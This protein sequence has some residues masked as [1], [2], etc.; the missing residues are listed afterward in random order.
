MQIFVLTYCVPSLP[1]PSTSISRRTNV[2]S[3]LSVIR[4]KKRYGIHYTDSRNM[5]PFRCMF[6]EIFVL[7]LPHLSSPHPLISMLQRIFSVT[8]FNLQQNKDTLKAKLKHLYCIIH[9]LVLLTCILSL[10]ALLSHCID[11]AT[12]KS[13]LYPFLAQRTTQQQVFC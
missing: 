3:C 5:P 8:F 11:V 9:N 6:Y 4:T 2:Y 10:L 13:S 12:N 1:A 7:L